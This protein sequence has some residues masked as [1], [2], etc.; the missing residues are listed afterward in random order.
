[1]SNEI[2]RFEFKDASLRALTDEAGEPWFVAKDACD[3]LGIDTNHLREALDDDEITNLRNSEVWNQPGRAPLIISE[4]GLY[5]LIMRSRK[6]EA[7][8]FQRWV[9]HEVLPQ[10]RKTGG[11]I[12]TSESDSDED[13]MSRAVLVAQKTIKQKNQQIAEQQKRIVE[14]EPKA[15]FADAVAAS[16]GTC[17]IGEL[18]KMLRQNGLK[19]GQNRLFRILRDDGYLGKSASNRNVPTQRAMELGLFRIKE[20]T[21]THA[22]G[23]TTVS[24]TPKVTGR[25]QGVLYPPVLPPAVVGSGCVMVLQQMMTTTQVARLFGA[26]TP[27][28]IRTRQGYLAQLRFRGQGPRFVKHGRMILYPETAV[29]EWLEEGETNCTR[30]IA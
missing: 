13:I 29:A 4:P 27:E 12:P 26:E 8:E 25:G 30:S 11:Y 2:Q 23:H 24:R 16:D 5:K 21:V 1:M 15:R 20:T 22:D 14:L 9:T 19:V 6:P 18:A 7:K 10:I 3:I 17:L 28:E